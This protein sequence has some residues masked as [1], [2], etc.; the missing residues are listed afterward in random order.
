MSYN[1]LLVDDSAS[2]RKVMRKVLRLS[3]LKVNDCYE[4]AN[5]DEALQI[6]NNHWVDL[7]LSDIHMPVMDGF[8]LL[9]ALRKEVAWRN[10]PVLLITTESNPDRL[11]TAM[12]LGAIGYIRKP[13]RPEEI[14]TVLRRILGEVDEHAME[15][16]DEECD[17]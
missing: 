12:D 7:I 6:L 16:E 5:G 4:A 1:I 14:R 8:E 11:Q 13:F 2:L 3:G 9:K 10:L 15:T 17:F